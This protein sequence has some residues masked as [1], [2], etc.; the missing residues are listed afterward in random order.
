[1]NESQYC[2][3]RMRGRCIAEQCLDTR[4]SMH[5]HVHVIPAARDCLVMAVGGTCSWAQTL[6]GGSERGHRRCGRELSE[7]MR[8]VTDAAGRE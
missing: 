5:E 3:F 1:M 4:V 2:I 7:G 6:R 8:V